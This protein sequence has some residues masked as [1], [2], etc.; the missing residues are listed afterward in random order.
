MSQLYEERQFR[1][2]MEERVISLKQQLEE[3][4]KEIKQLK[5]EKYQYVV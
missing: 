3:A 1:D 4:R 2:R 5:S